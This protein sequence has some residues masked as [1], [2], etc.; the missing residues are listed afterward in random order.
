MERALDRMQL[1]ADAPECLGPAV[2]PRP[3]TAARP[4]LVPE[5]PT[6][7]RLPIAG[8]SDGHSMDKATVRYVKAAFYLD[9]LTKDTGCIRVIPG[10]YS[11]KYFS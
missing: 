9:E 2:R 1:E 4:R 5:M 8:H 11:V 10:T 3:T 6:P 7:I